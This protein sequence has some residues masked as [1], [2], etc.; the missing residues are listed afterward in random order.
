MEKEMEKDFEV[1]APK[2]IPHWR[3][4]I[5]RARV[6]QDVLTHQYTGEG[7]AEDPFIVTWIPNDPGNPMQFSPSKKWFVS[8]IAAV[9]MLATAFNSSA[10]SGSIREII[11]GFD[12]SIEVATLGVS[13]FVLG[14]ALGPLIWAPLSEMYGRQVVFAISYGGFTAF[15]A[16]APASKNIQTL[17]VL[18]FFAGSF[19]SSP[20]TNAGGQIADIFNASERGLAMGLFALAPFLGPTIGPIAGGF[21]GQSKGWKWVEGL[22]TIFSGVMWIFGLLFVPETYAPVL[23]QKRAEKLS[24]M[25]GKVYRTQGDAAGRMAASKRLQIALVRPWILL[26]K[27]PIV[28]VLS[29]YM[30]IIYGTLYMLFGALPICFQEVRGWSEGIGGLAFLG[31]AVGMIFA[32]MLVPLG[33]KQYRRAAA[34]HGGIAPPEARLVSAMAGAVA[35]PLGLFWFAWTNYA[36]IHW[37]SS[38]MAGA[39]FGF[40]MVVIFLAV[41]NYLIDAYTIFAASVLAA[42][43]V[44]RSLFGFAFPLFTQYMYANLGIHWAS[45]VPAFL[46]LAC[47]PAPFFLYRYGA[48]IRARCEYAAQS[49]AVMRSL[50][51]GQEVDAGDGTGEQGNTSDEVSVGGET[52]SDEEDHVPAINK[53]KTSASKASLRAAG[54]AY[55]TSPFDLD[56]V[57]THDSLSGLPR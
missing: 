34:E 5:D 30:A 27:E 37:I 33:N 28:L 36:S 13:L 38:V 16:A 14:F 56:R 8:G 53:T 42:N 3:L 31:V 19:G 1:E 39:P 29:I 21:L 6:T 48:S 55:H 54:T 11:F 24:L 18:R 44:L 32:V 50:R 4:I 20:L 45:S 49:E 46:A 52:V 57:H 26:F 41:T 25:T 40:G 7:T 43:S 35:I 23:L 17:L 15:N 2:S 22:M 12:I 9:S 47:L 51:M 10:F